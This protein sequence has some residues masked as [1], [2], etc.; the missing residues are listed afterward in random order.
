MSLKSFIFFQCCSPY[1]RKVPRSADFFNLRQH[2][3]S[4]FLNNTG[5]TP[6]GKVSI[7]NILVKDDAS[8]K[9]LPFFCVPLLTGRKCIYYLT[10]VFK[11]VFLQTNKLE[12]FHQGLFRQ[13]STWEGLFNRKTMVF[14]SCVQI[15]IIQIG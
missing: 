11:L 2:S 12:F 10:L 14:D 4:F 8:K 1:N 7:H 13:L 15:L 6:R 9:S 3:N 5:F